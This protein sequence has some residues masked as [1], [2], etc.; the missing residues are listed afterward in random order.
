MILFSICFC[1]DI[2][3]YLPTLTIIIL[4]AQVTQCFLSTSILGVL[5]IADYT[6]TAEHVL[7]HMVAHAFFAI[8]SFWFYTTYFGQV[9]QWVQSLRVWNAELNKKEAEHAQE[10]FE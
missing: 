5:D 8:C 1:V 6:F 3:L 2:V 9:P 7:G 4:L 10:E